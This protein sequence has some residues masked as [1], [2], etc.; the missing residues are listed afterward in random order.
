[1]GSSEPKQFLLLNGKPVIWHT[2]SA[3]LSAFHDTEIILVLPEDRLSTGSEITRAFES[4]NQIAI[5]GGGETRFHSV[6][7]GLSLIRDP[8]IV[9]VHDGV[10]CMVTPEL[11]KRC[12]NATVEK[13]NAVPVITAIDSLRVETKEGN[14]IID[15][16]N[17]KI[18]Q[19]P[20]TFRSD[21]LLGAFEQEYNLDF[22]DEASVVERSGVKINL[23]EGDESNFKITRPLDLLVAEKIFEERQGK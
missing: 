21:I 4:P 17:V 13:G 16:G 10:R 9:F 2:L 15:R 23:V 8:S 20:Q 7:K 12:Y 6:K 1:M 18:V 19:T 5:V 14:K 3:F 22:T 11:I